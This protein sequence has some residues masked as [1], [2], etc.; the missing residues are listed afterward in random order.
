MTAHSILGAGVVV[1]LFVGGCNGDG[2]ATVTTTTTTTTVAPATTTTLDPL[3]AEEAAVSEAAEAGA[4]GEIERVRE[5]RRPGRH[6]RARP[7]LR[8]R[9]PGAGRGRRVAHRPPR[10]KVGVV[11]PHPTVPESLTVEG[12]TF[13]RRPADQAERWSCALSTLG[14]STSRAPLLTVATRLSTTSCTPIE[15]NTSC[16]RRTA[17]GSWPASPA[18]MSGRE[19]TSCPPIAL[20]VVLAVGLTPCID[21]AGSGGGSSQRREAEGCRPDLRL[22]QQR[23]HRRAGS[24]AAV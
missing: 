5:P 4:A 7:V 22:G 2:E 18:L 13:R 24:G 19:S 10:P 9:K 6:C 12:V 20:A 15:A 23:R 1:A 16:R 11:R 21:P 14:S 17:R 3:A 8:R